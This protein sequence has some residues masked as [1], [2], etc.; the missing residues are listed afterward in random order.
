M[1]LGKKTG[2]FTRRNII[3]IIGI[4]VVAGVTIGAIFWMRSSNEYN[5][6]V[7]VIMNDDD[8]TKKEYNIPGTGT[9][10]DPYRIEDRIIETSRVYAIWIADTTKF[11]I[12]K[13][14]TLTS[15]VGIYINS[16]AEDTCTI[17]NNTI[18]LGNGN[19]IGINIESSPYSN[20]NRNNVKSSNRDDSGFGITVLDSSYTTI[21]RNYCDNIS[22]GIQCWGESSNIIISQNY[23]EKC[24]IGIMIDSEDWTYYGEYHDVEMSSQTVTNNTC[25]NNKIGIYFFKDISLSDIT[26]NNCSFNTKTGINIYSCQSIEISYNFVGN[27]TEGIRLNLVDDSLIYNNQINLNDFYGLNITNSESNMIYY[28]NFYNNNYA[29]III[30]ESQ[31]FDSTA[32]SNSW[33]STSLDEGN[34]WS[35]LVWSSG[36]TYS[37]DGGTNIDPYPLE[38]PVVL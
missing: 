12:I 8:F 35:E 5:N 27:N 17:T 1:S 34:F 26:Y 38:F 16:V 37:L 21:S 36:I 4:V 14:C 13:N 24:V 2:F 11:F 30:D 9:E 7:I 15:F 29:G 18:L 23:C 6:G 28:N 31:A 3:I 10:V 32:A 25:F 20:I 19:S 33:Y 22:Y